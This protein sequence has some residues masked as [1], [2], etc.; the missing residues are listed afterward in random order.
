MSNIQDNWVKTFVETCLSKLPPIYTALVTIL[1]IVL[2]LGLQPPN[3]STCN[4]KKDS[5]IQNQ[6]HNGHAEYQRLQPGMS[7]V[8]AESILG[9]G[10][11]IER[12]HTTAIFVWEN[13]DC[14]S[15]IAV[16]ENGKLKS[17]RQSKLQYGI[18]PSLEGN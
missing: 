9:R 2:G 5:L 7:L 3:L 11:E 12:S 8:E 17:K 10:N 4:E 1:V 16:F 15:I 18:I 14:S 13:L 6:Q